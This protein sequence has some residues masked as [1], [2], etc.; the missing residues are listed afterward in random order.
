MKKIAFDW[1]RIGKSLLKETEKSS[2]EINDV[3]DKLNFLASECGEI[4]GSRKM[5]NRIGKILI[6][7][8]PVTILTPCCQTL[9]AGSKI[10]VEKHIAFLQKVFKIIPSISPLFL[11]A[12][13]ESEDMEL[14]LAVGKTQEEF[15]LMTK[16]SIVDISSLIESF[17][18]KTALMLEI[19]PNLI[20]RENEIAQWIA[21]E[22]QFKARLITETAARRNLYHNI[23]RA[24]PMTVKEQMQRT[25]KTAAQYVVMGEFANQNNFLICNH[26]TSNL[27]WYLQTEAAILHNPI[28]PY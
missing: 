27:A 3:L 24:K 8:N 15:Y 25:I 26:T 11:V 10:L 17:G 28:S 21:N 5:L 13:H 19:I 20:Q 9:N 4:T 12:D 6:T 23:Y 16:K 22:N 7:Q 14:C 2:E 18:W 1:K